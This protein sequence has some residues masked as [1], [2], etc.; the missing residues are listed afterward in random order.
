MLGYMKRSHVPLNFRSLYYQLLYFPNTLFALDFHR[1]S[2]MILLALWNLWSVDLASGN[3]SNRMN[4]TITQ[5][6]IA[7]DKWL[8]LTRRELY[9][10]LN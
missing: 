4:P 8:L 3:E 10:N 1:I 6:V 5:L 7:V 9:E 2:C